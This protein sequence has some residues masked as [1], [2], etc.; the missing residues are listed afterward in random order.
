MV[1]KEFIGNS[2][3]YYGRTVGTQTSNAK[4]KLSDRAN[5][6]G[7]FYQLCKANNIDVSVTNWTFGSHGLGS[8]I[9]DECV[10]DGD[11]KGINHNDYLTDKY[12]DYVVVSP[13][14]GTAS[15]ND[16]AS[17]FETIEK[18]FKE[19]NPN[20]KII[21][22]GNASGQ[23]VN[24][25]DTAYPLITGY[26]KTFYANGGLVADWGKLVKDIIEGKATVEGAT[27]EYNKKTFIVKDNYHPNLLSGYITTLFTFCT[28]TGES[29]VGQ[30]YAYLTDANSAPTIDVDAYVTKYYTNGD[31]DTT[32]PEIVNSE[33]DIRGIQKLVD[34]Y[35]EA[36]HFLNY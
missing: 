16:I 9:G 14:V 28:I 25:S 34:E 30:P 7:G 21:L 17:H 1:R 19:A 4:D 20:V 27:Q 35:I 2:H 3:I 11:C 15:S 31:A 8:I 24:A 36:K 29:A 12:Y 5:D 10:T 26:Y 6:K 13:G 23:G 18:I 22:L 33:S 32:F